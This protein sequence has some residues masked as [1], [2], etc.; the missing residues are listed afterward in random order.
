[1]VRAQ[2]LVVGQ[3]KRQILSVLLVEGN[4][5]LGTDVLKELRGVE[6]RC[7]VICLDEGLSLLVVVIRWAHLCGELV[8]IREGCVI[9]RKS[10]CIQV[11]P[12][13]VVTQLNYGNS[14]LLGL[15][16]FVNIWELCHEFTFERSLHLFLERVS[17]VCNGSTV[18]VVGRK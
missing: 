8:V 9:T 18:L 5:N 11:G 15:H 2:G 4:V 7:V 16:H 10:D 17:E 12:S 1:M 3:D 14:R 6:V 13:K